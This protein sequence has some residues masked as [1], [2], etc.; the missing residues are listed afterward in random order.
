MRILLLTS[1]V[2]FLV[3]CDSGGG[4]SD[5]V[6][7]NPGGDDAAA[8]SDAGGEDPAPG[9]TLSYEG[10]IGGAAFSGQCG[11]ADGPDF[12]HLWQTTFAQVKCEKKAEKTT[13][14][15]KIIGEPRVQAYPLG[16]PSAQAYVLPSGNG[17]APHAGQAGT[18][19]VTAWDAETDHLV[20]TFELTW[21]EEIPS[22]GG[23]LQTRQGS[24][25]G[26]FDVTL[27]M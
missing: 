19:T 14:E 2:C 1:A 13:L 10:T 7:G 24:V 26:A 17:H 8:V 9:G 16:G 5:A 3:A 15:V 4:G 23:T 6:G 22:A 21:S 20:G 18:L 25:T 12:R 11:A 27:G